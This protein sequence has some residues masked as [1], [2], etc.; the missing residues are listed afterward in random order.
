MINEY[1]FLVPP[2]LTGCEPTLLA[3]LDER[4][5]LALMRRRE[6]RAVAVAAGV[7][8]SLAEFGWAH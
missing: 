7:N 8:Q 2:G 4:I 3:D 1:E 5:E 6:F